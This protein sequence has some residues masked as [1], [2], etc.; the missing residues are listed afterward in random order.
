MSE[1]VGRYR[2]F[3]VPAETQE[4]QLLK[5]FDRA[6][7]AAAFAKLVS[8][9]G[10]Y[11][12]V[13]VEAP[14]GTDEQDDRSRELSDEQYQFRSR[15]GCLYRLLY[16]GSILGGGLLSLAFGFFGALCIVLWL[17]DATG[18]RFGPNLVIALGMF[19]AA[20]LTA[21]VVKLHAA[22]FRERGRR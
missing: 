3:G 18:L 15:P 12:Q 11:L 5:T 22:V 7:E 10:R 8:A 19:L 6:C 17:A 14:A 4:E 1:R 21:L 9:G 2:V 16:I 20:G 13:R